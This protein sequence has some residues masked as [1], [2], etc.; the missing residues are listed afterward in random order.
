M[1]F[2]TNLLISSLLKYFKSSFSLTTLQDTKYAKYFC[3]SSDLRVAS[4]S[5]QMYTCLYFRSG[6]RSAS[7][8]LVPKSATPVDT[9][10]TAQALAASSTS[11]AVSWSPQVNS[12][13]ELPYLYHL[14]KTLL[15]KLLPM[16]SCKSVV[17][18]VQTVI[19]F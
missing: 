3:M 10:E 1:L 16:A 12:F 6:V 11:I 17:Q 19:A 9:C 2:H 7:F 5:K 18:S 4:A 15:L 14:G 13:D 8:K